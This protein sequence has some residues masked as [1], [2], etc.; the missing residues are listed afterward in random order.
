[1]EQT[2]ASILGDLMKKPVPKKKQTFVIGTQKKKRVDISE[3]GAAPFDDS[4]S[5][6]EEQDIAPSSKISKI[7]K[8]PKIVDR[9]ETGFNRNA[10]LKKVGKTVHSPQQDVVTKDMEDIEDKELERIFEEEEEE[11]KE[12]VKQTE[13]REEEEELERLFD[14]DNKDEEKPTEDRE[15]DD[16]LD[17]ILQAEE[18]KKKQTKTRKEPKEPKEPK[19]S[20]TTTRKTVKR[21]K[22]V[23]EA[24]KRMEV[25]PSEI[26]IDGEPLTERLP[27]RKRRADSN[28]AVGVPHIRLP[29]Y[30]MNNRE[31]FINFINQAFS[32]YKDEL[33][34]QTDVTCE[35][36]SSDDDGFFTLMTHQKIVRDYLTNYTPYRGLLLYH[37][38]GSGKTCSS[39]AI[40]EGLKTK[41]QVIVMTPASLRTNYIEELKKCGDPL[42][43]KN[44]H[45]EFI[46][47]EG[48]KD[49]LPSLAGFMGL[50]T[51]DVRN[52]VWLVDA[53]KE[54]NYDSLITNEQ[55]A[56]DKQLDKM[57]SSKY[58][59]ISYN[60]MNNRMFN[61]M[62]ND[63]E[64]N[65][66]DNKVII[67]D[68]VHNF[69]SRIVNKLS[70]SKKVRDNNVSIKM[71][72]MI[73]QAHNSRL[74]FL[75]GTPIINYPNELAVLF[76]ML[77][78]Y[79]QTWQFK[80]RSEKTGKGTEKINEKFIQSLF[81]KVFVS[82][83]V[84]YSPTSKLVTITRNPYSFISRYKGD[85]YKGVTMDER[86]EVS[87]QDFIKMIQKVLFKYSRTG[88][89]TLSIEGGTSK[90]VKKNHKA[91]PDKYDTFK[92]YFLKEN[93]SVENLN[94]F[95]RRIVGLTSYYRSAQEQLMPTFDKNRDFHVVE[96]D[97]SQYQLSIYEK[98]RKKERKEEKRLSMKKGDDIYETTNSTYRVFSRAACNFVFPEGMERPKPRE[99]TINVEAET[100]T[101][102]EVPLDE[103]PTDDQL[104]EGSEDYKTRIARSIQTLR[105]SEYM[106]IQNEEDGEI[107]RETGLG[108][109]SP[110]FATIITNLLDEEKVGCHLIYS[111]FRSVEGIEL[112][113]V[114]MNA[115]GF[116]RFNIAKDDSG[117]WTIDVDKEAVREGKPMYALYTGTESSEEREII[118]NFFNSN[119]ELVPSR[120]IR[121]IQKLRKSENRNIMG[122]YVK[123]FMITASG[124]EGISLRNTR[125]VH[126]V[127]PHWHPVRIEQVIGRARRICSH[128]ELPQELRTVEVYMYLMH[129]QPDL[130]KDH[131]YTNMNLRDRGRITSAVLTSDEYLYEISSIKE[132]TNEQLLD[133]IKSSSMDCMI[134]ADA[135]T[136]CMTFG[137]VQSDSFAY[138]PSYGK[139]Q[140]DEIRNMNTRTLTWKGRELKVKKKDQNG[141][142][143]L[144]KDGNPMYTRYIMK[145]N[146]NEL[147]DYDS[148]MNS[149]KSGAN[150]L[151][152][153]TLQQR[154]TKK[155]IEL[156]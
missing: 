42:Y 28:D 63:G 70:A 103:I 96:I 35:S 145:Q 130:I 137:N 134:H 51:R 80:L 10:F 112:L 94:L 136:K 45:W 150:P 151:R 55:Q 76:N 121:K 143:L 50:S 114:A 24:E 43:K 15:G 44:Q 88:T 147:Y 120:I 101:E 58:Q 139:E 109:Y 93:G 108:K 25:D 152:V 4:E 90:I 122:D 46:S 6:E 31:K 20:K 97:M 83:Y 1:M 17:K 95:Q 32:E 7:S 138:K 106:L 65:I 135:E 142:Q 115:N 71:Y 154:G 113:T 8:I 102:T 99:G 128:Q 92:D 123:V 16:E 72:N 12:E 131:D 52:G 107:S 82:D 73:L 87:D 22:D 105:D 61:Q 79:I 49:I 141:R 77:R 5:Q 30:Y 39:I 155:V 67:I 36:R 18:D 75:S 116:T 117:K 19:A 78:G 144:D 11:E 59:F 57:I 26:I 100:E 133:S 9:R 84:S 34:E 89:Y 69:V 156:L 47:L 126:I 146:T 129:I 3:S 85:E 124:A 2:K 54:P 148:Y 104:A 125:Y 81:K 27:R 153:G 23:R 48:R 33:R 38:L 127:E 149:M 98:E 60:G 119:W 37:G 132:K 21:T 64:K 86:G 13:G 41:R 14:E 111:Q 29:R 110:K 91:L 56:I 53:N 66:F 140:R 62:T 40:A 118:R 74:V 68:E